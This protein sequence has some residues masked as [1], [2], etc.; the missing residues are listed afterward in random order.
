MLAR[1]NNE[2]ELKCD[3]S[4]RANSSKMRR[5]GFPNR[6]VSLMKT[7]RGKSNVDIRLGEEIEG[8]RATLTRWSVGM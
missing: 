6:M 8:G 1:E 2:F 3:G 5:V 7:L 4:V